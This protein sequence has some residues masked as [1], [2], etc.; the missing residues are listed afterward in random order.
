MNRPAINSWDC[1][2][3]FI[4]SDWPK[5]WMC[6][7]NSVLC[8]LSLAV[9]R[10]PVFQLGPWQQRH[11]K[12]TC[13]R[14]LKLPG[15]VTLCCVTASCICGKPSLCGVCWTSLQRHG[16]SGQEQAMFSSWTA[17]CLSDPSHLFLHHDRHEDLPDRQFG[18]K[19]CSKVSLTAKP[20]HMKGTWALNC[21]R[22]I[23]SNELTGLV[24]MYLQWGRT[25]TL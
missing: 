6:L 1:T 11:V 4:F 19:V 10:C 8:S 13:S 16:S 22:D 14:G 9:R 15:N 12:G 24:W 20:W 3:L 5:D 21:W 17:C 25:G 23:P 18:S 7:T 2:E